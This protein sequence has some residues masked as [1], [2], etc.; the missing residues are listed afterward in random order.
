MVAV[1]S[2]ETLMPT[3]KSALHHNPEDDYGNVQV[4]SFFRVPLDL[5]EQNQIL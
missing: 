1:S 5:N 2:S 3:Y 4:T